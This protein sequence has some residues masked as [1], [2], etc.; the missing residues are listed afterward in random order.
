MLN[1]LIAIMSDVFEQETEKRV[2]KT[3]STKLQ[4]LADQAHMLRDHSKVPYK[5]VFMVVIVTS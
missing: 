1:M 2:V 3:N 4:I 5:K